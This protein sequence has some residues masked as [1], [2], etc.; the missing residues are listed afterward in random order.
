MA[1]Y[2]IQYGQYKEMALPNLPKIVI[3]YSYVVHLKKIRTKTVF[4][5]LEIE[6][7]NFLFLGTFCPLGHLVLG[8]FCLLEPFFLGTLCLRTFC[9]GTF[10]PSGRFICAP[11][12]GQ[13]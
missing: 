13:L 12:N 11:Q 5:K 9:L 10:L 6:V 4:A 1:L 8:T 7:Y 2:L 3:I